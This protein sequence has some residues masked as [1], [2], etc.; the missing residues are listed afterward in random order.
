M[1]RTSGCSGRARSWRRGLGFGF[2]IAKTL[3]GLRLGLAL[4]LLLVAA[5]VFLFALSRLGGV[6]L[7]T[8]GCFLF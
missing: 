8:L 2:L 7:G 3:L 4:G 1:T 6:A 5:T